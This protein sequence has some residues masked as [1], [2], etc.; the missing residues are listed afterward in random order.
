MAI[1]KCIW[2]CWKANSFTYHLGFLL[3]KVDSKSGL[4]IIEFSGY[5]C[6]SLNTEKISKFQLSQWV[7]G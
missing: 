7:W 3:L 6:K 2:C 1:L 5:Y 4:S